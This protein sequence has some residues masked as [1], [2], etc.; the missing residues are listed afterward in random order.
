MK[1][2]KLPLKIVVLDRGWVFVGRVNRFD[3]EITIDEACCVRYWG[4]TNG[5]RARFIGSTAKDQARSDAAHRSTSAGTAVHHRLRR[6]QMDQLQVTLDGAGSGS[7]YGG[8]DPEDPYY[9][10]GQGDGLSFG[11]DQDSS[12]GDGYGYGSGYG[13]GHGSGSGSS[14]G[15]GYGVG[16]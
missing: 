12:C 6:E 11:A 7:A 13:P 5:L 4:T 3:D 16:V 15:S 9:G 10:Y 2:K 8:G 14:G 1:P